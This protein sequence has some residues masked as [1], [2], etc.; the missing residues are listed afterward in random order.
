VQDG[1]DWIVRHRLYER[2][3]TRRLLE[4]GYG[5]GALEISKSVRA[6]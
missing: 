1:I 4:W 6:Q 5:S 2:R 3:S